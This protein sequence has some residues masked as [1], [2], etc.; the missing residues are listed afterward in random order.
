MIPD[1]KFQIDRTRTLL[2]IWNQKSAMY[3]FNESQTYGPQNWE[4]FCATADLLILALSRVALESMAP[5]TPLGRGRL[6]RTAAEEA[7]RR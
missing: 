5:H 1:S 6:S 4:A 2:L 7:A 3:V